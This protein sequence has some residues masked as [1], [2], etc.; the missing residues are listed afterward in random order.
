MKQIFPKILSQHFFFSEK[1]YYKLP[2]PLQSR[3]MQ[4]PPR[5]VLYKCRNFNGSALDRAGE[6]C[7]E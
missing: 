6:I 3:V 1:Y 5:Y 4:H 7:P 2:V